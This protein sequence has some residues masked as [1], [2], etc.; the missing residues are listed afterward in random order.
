MNV[1]VWATTFG[2]DLW[3]FTRYL[4][5]RDDCRV[6]VVL[7]DARLFRREG[8]AQLFPLQRTPLVTR[9]PWHRLLG[10][11][12]G[13][14]PDVTVMD[15]RVPLRAKGAGLMLWHGFGWRGPNDADTDFAWIHRALGQAF[16]GAR[17][18][19]PRFVWQTFGPWDDEHRTE[20]SGMHPAN[21]RQ[22]GAVSHDDLRVPLDRSLAQPFYPFDVVGR[23]TV[24]LAPTWHYGEV[25]A[26][27][28]RDADL[29]ER[30]L[31]HLHRRNVNVILRLHDSFR[32]EKPYRR[33]LDGLAAR[34]PNVLLKFKD[35]HPDNF[36]D[37]QVADVLVTNFSS[38]ANLF[39]ATGRPTVHV[40]PVAHADEAF[41][42][43]EYTVLGVRKTEVESA[44]FMWK[45]PP[46]DNGGLLAHD[47]DEM[48]AQIDRGLD[49]P[50]C[51]EETAQAFLDRHMLGA[52]GHN[53]ERAFA[54]LQEL[55]AAG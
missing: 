17:E 33:F 29:F 23:R 16:G 30:L 14:R 44:R 3:S 8:A 54:A 18:P 38:I 41:M 47:F 40:Y 50:G 22:I 42:R 11:V 55:A 28:G 5:G 36:L 27:W 48:M 7:P 26:H 31:S 53:A 21:T 12:P 45:L 1:L 35:H 15:N 39:Y 32:F 4:D 43:R 34:Y 13:F 6:R 2:A 24:L 19:N 52:D 25:F 46:E 20:V 10:T 49:E 51:C 37:L 9:R